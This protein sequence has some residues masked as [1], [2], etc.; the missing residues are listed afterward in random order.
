[1][2]F[3]H[4]NYSIHNLTIKGIKR[5]KNYLKP[6]SAKL[7]SGERKRMYSEFAIFI[8]TNSLY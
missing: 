2:N 6:Q 7:Y 8:I 4:M 3:F 5:K 1:M